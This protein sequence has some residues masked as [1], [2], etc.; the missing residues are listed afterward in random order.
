MDQITYFDSTEVIQNSDTC[1]LNSI[2]NAG[3][4]LKCFQICKLYSITC[5]PHEQYYKRKGTLFYQ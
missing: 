1:K 5:W 2:T 4:I 3:K